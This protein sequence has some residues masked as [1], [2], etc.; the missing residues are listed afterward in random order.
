MFQHGMIGSSCFI[1]VHPHRRIAPQADASLLFL[2]CLS[3][4]YHQVPLYII[5]YYYFTCHYKSINLRMKEESSWNIN[6]GT[7]TL[8]ETQSWKE[9]GKVKKTTPINQSINQIPLSISIYLSIH[10][11][12]YLNL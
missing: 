6:N 4:I 9:K 5:I 1:N 2:F 8:Y 12:L 11:H 3:S 7:T 10:P